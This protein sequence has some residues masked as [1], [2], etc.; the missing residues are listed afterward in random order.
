MSLSCLCTRGVDYSLVHLEL[1]I[2]VCGQGKAA[3]RGLTCTA[4]QQVSG[5]QLLQAFPT[6]NFLSGLT[7]LSWALNKN[8]R[9][10]TCDP[11]AHQGGSF[12]T[13]QFDPIP[14]DKIEKV[15]ECVCVWGGLMFSLVHS[16]PS[17]KT[18]TIPGRP[19]YVFSFTCGVGYR[20]PDAPTLSLSGV[21]GILH[22]RPINLISH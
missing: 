20:S 3:G 11:R 19:A 21:S 12:T 1:V 22:H 7:S 9:R 14:G 10:H 18:P 16:P 8:F 2:R 15:C 13:A 17:L 4:R 5:H 6:G